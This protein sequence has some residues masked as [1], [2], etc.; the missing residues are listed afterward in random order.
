MTAARTRTRV[1]LALAAVTALGLGL[2]H[3]TGPGRCWVNNFGPAS[4]AYE[5]FFMLLVFLLVPRRS[6]IV[7]IAVGVCAGT[8]ILEVL[9]TWKPPWL[10]AVRAT[11]LGRTLLGTTFSWWDF[12]AYVV[13]CALGWVLLLWLSRPGRPV[14]PRERGQ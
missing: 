5:L 10:E 8:C 12:P 14:G 11:F 13:G 3:Y 1:L 2:K 9:Q 7:P 6:A 4:V